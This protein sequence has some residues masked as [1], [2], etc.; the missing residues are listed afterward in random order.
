MNWQFPLDR[1]KGAVSFCYANIK[2]NKYLTDNIIISNVF[3]KY[4]CSEYKK[5]LGDD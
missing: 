2:F 1:K 5:E 3:L 4:N